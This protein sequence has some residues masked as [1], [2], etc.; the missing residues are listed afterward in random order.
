LFIG[1]EHTFVPVS[2]GY[3]AI[4]RQ[5]ATVQPILGLGVELQH[6]FVPD[7]PV[8]R[9]GSVYVEFGVGFALTERWSVGAMLAMDVS[10][11][12]GM[13]AG[14]DPRVHVGYRF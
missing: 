4:F 1:P 14:V 13:G 11:L 2:L 12:G 8:V 10:V 7:Y 6:R 9:A 3:R 5:G